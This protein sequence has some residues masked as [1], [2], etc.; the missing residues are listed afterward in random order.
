MQD[1]YLLDLEDCLSGYA[2]VLVASVV[3]TAAFTTSTALYSE[4]VHSSSG[5]ISS[6]IYLKSV[7][8]ISVVSFP[9]KTSLT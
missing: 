6:S 8:R 5:G 9:L 2:T 3:K 1:V 7:I 4:W